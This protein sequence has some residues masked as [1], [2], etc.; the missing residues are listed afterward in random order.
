MSGYDNLFSPVSLGKLKLENRVSMAPTYLGMAAFGGGVTDVLV[1][2]YRDMGASGAALVV[3]ENAAV[4]PSGMGSPMTM[5]VDSDEF[6]DGLRK[7][8]SA[9]KEGGAVAVQQINYAGRFAYHKEKWGASPA[10]IADVVV[11]EMPLGEI[12]RTAAA[13][14]KSAKLVKDAGFDGVE[15]H[16]GTGY[17]LVQFLSPLT[18]RRS[19]DFGGALENRMRFP[20]MVVDAVRDAVGPDFPVG[21]RFLA[22][23][24]LPDGLHAKETDVFAAELVRRGI[25]YLSVMAGT[26]DSFFLPDYLKAEREQGYMVHFAGHIKKHIEGA[27][28]I[29]AGRIQSPEFAEEIISSGKADMVGLARVLLA[30]PLWPKKAAGEIDEPINI[31]EPTCSFCMKRIMAGKPGYCIRWPRE[32]RERFLAGTGESLED[33]EQ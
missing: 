1:N 31:C 13:Y 12:E 19:D 18:N 24:W 3:V 23:E 17:L 29:T 21:Y 15:I 16:G 32:R 33:E 14:A 25:D 6:L 11:K 26:Y 20:L 2:H 9:V 22:D 28:V 5:R 27:A 4:D 8:S 7:V 10:E 30:D